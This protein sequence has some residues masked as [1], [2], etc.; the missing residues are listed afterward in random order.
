MHVGVFF[1]LKW[2]AALLEIDV[3]DHAHSLLSR[4]IDNNTMNRRPVKISLHRFCERQPLQINLE[5]TKSSACHLIKLIVECFAALNGISPMQGRN[6]SRNMGPW[7][8][9]E[10]EFIII[11]NGER[12]LISLMDIT[13]VRMLMLFDMINGEQLSQINTSRTHM[14]HTTSYMLHA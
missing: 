13:H 6:Q 9:Y 11:I 14:A 2:N 12:V 1:I 4:K 7:I 3:V 8:E 5:K 10:R